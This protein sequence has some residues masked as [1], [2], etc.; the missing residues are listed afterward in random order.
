MTRR[1]EHYCTTWK[2]LEKTWHVRVTWNTNSR[3][4]SNGYSQ[5]GEEF[6]VSSQNHWT[7]A[8]LPTRG[9]RSC[10]SHLTHGWPAPSRPLTILTT[11]KGSCLYNRDSIS[12]PSIRW[13]DQRGIRCLHAA[14]A[15]ASQ[16]GRYPGCI[17]RNSSYSLSSR[18]ILK[19]NWPPNEE[20]WRK[21][22][23]SSSMRSLVCFEK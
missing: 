22:V 7:T 5:P 11:E 2:S 20:F 6:R 1:D 15:T 13:K 3:N 16:W 10:P 9:A 14:A 12:T 23:T 4:E 18:K 21:K 19:L 17:I 8:G